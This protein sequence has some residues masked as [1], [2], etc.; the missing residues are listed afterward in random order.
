MMKKSLFFK[1]MLLLGT[2]VLLWNSFAQDWSQSHLPEGAIARIGTGGADEITFS[3]NGKHLV[4]AN[5]IGI[6][7]YD[8]HTGEDLTVLTGHNTRVKSIVFSRDGKILMSSGEDG[9]ARLWDVNTGKLK[10]ELKGHQS[11]VRR[12]VLS[13][14]GNT[15]ASVA[16]SI[17]NAGGNIHLWSP[18][19]GQLKHILTG[20][21]GN[22]DNVAFS[23]DEKTLVSSENWPDPIIF[24]WDTN[25][26]K[27]RHTLTGPNGK[28]QGVGFSPDG[29]TLVSRGQDSIL[30]LWNVNTGQ[31]KN[32][33]IGHNGN[34][35]SVVFSPNGKT[36]ASGGA[37]G[38]I[39]L[40][41]P[42][43]GTSIRTLT[44]HKSFVSTVKF[45]PDGKTLVSFSG[46]ENTIYLWNPNTGKLKHTLTGHKSF[47]STVKFSPD[48]KT[49]VSFSGRENTIYLWNPNTGKLKYTFTGHD[50]KV[51]DVKLSPDGKTIVSSGHDGIRLWNPNTG[52]NIRTLEHYRAHTIAFSPDG[53]TIAGGW[54]G[55][56]RLWDANTRTHKR[57][58]EKGHN[59][60]VR[61]I[62]FSPNG[63]TIV[64]S[65][66]G[67]LQDHQPLLWDANTGKLKQKLSGEFGKYLIGKNGFPNLIFSPDGNTIFGSDGHAYLWDA[68]TG[69]V[70]GKLT[71]HKYRIG[72]IALSPDGSTIVGGGTSD[73]RLWD[74]TTGKLKQ[75]FT[76]HTHWVDSAAFSPDGNTIASGSRDNTLR[77]WDANTG[78]LKLPPI[79]HTNWVG[80]VAFSPDGNTIASSKINYNNVPID[81]TVYLWD[82][83][84]G[85]LKRK[86]TGHASWI[87][88]LV[89]SPDGSTL[90]SASRMDGT[91]LL[92][93]IAPVKQVLVA[94]S[95]RSPM[96]WVNTTTGTLHRLVGAKIENLAPSVKKATNLAVDT[97]NSK[98]YW[99]TKINN[100]NGKIQR[101]NLDGTNVELVKNLTSVPL[102]IAVDTT[103]GKLYLTN[104]WGKL[105]RLNLDGSDFQ[106]NLITG[107]QSP[108]HLALDVQR[109]KI[110]WTEQTDDS[111][112]KVRS[113]N[114]D[115]SDVQLVKELTSPPQ[116]IAV[117][118]VNKKL[119]L[120]SASGH[121]Q[122]MTLVGSYFRPNLIT[123]LGSLGEISVDTSGRKL[124]WTESGRIRRANFNG[125]NI[126]DIVTRIG[127]PAGV[128]LGVMSTDGATAAPATMAAPEQTL[129]L[130]NYPNPFNPETWIP[131][132]LAKPAAVT[133][134]I[135]NVRGVVVRRLALG[136]QLAGVYHSRSRAIHWDGRNRVGEKVASGIYFYTFTAG[137]FT[138]TRKLLIRK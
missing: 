64:S 70:K 95:Q 136:H 114:L 133:L 51:F 104:S 8:A 100:R 50:R 41:N 16:L 119:Y 40:W 22:P 134:T 123:G 105:Q 82:A 90:A 126:Q 110:Y 45:S 56:I 122:R 73:L 49:L 72:D 38:T 65:G 5:S 17:P 11:F 130:S 76:G 112:G 89:F 121:I 27:L 78:K 128:A 52:T 115:G 46:R 118:V 80:S 10:H 102:D 116:G 71:G 20:H 88:S 36:L 111:T 61:A 109:G 87:S 81:G 21:E 44:G 84:T 96:Y 101:A 129:L 35:L 79:E 62:A 29:K 107:L 60:Q 47:V 18:R 106:P 138:A 135:Y 3:P 9:I 14:D 57:T 30:Y 19:T 86:L 125:K 37:D 12:A 63:N 93:E 15:L 137:D 6:W 2:V 48:G 99:A 33:L 39:Q 103:N 67:G 59:T 34:I 42:N 85:K 74:A 26:G 77:L 132:Q 23:P 13:P 55:L 97:T 43:T 28:I 113:A 54:S 124:Y 25:T 127:T 1:C 83:N 120:T 68:N 53:N 7:I 66:L 69:E 24:L 91:T 75:R 58:F 98:L 108:N 92:W 4:I 32:T 94:A 117:D 31:L 131:Y